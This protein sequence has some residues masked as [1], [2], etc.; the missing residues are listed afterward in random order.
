MGKKSKK[1]STEAFML[2]WKANQDATDW[3]TFTTAIRAAHKAAGKDEPD[4]NSINLRCARIN[5]QIRRSGAT[6]QY[7]KPKWIKRENMTI[8]ELLKANPDL[9]PSG[10]NEKDKSA[11]K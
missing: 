9:I 3:N 5:A 4:D 1:L 2:A 8:A 11:A 6:W 7:R 10:A